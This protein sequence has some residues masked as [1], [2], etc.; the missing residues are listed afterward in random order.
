MIF[1]RQLANSFINFKS[2]CLCIVYKSICSINITNHYDSKNEK[3]NKKDNNLSEEIIHPKEINGR[4]G[5][6]PI[7]Y[8]DWEYKGKCVDF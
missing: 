4:K 8:N 2:N 7:R 6:D 1:L 5:L 3:D